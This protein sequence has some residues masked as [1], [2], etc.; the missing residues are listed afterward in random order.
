MS[1]C[2]SV[3]QVRPG[4]ARPSPDPRTPPLAEVTSEGGLRPG[5]GLTLRGA[6]AAMCSFTSG[7]DGVFSGFPNTVKARLGS[8]SWPLTLLGVLA[9]GLRDPRALRL[10]SLLLRASASSLDP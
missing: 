4:L 3:P 1:S 10:S 2:A 9:W 6:R 7:V 5:P 8:G